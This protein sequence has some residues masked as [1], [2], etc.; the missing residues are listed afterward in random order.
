MWF[1]TLAVIHPP[2]TSLPLVIALS[3]LGLSCG[4]NKNDDSPTAPPRDGGVGDVQ[5]QEVEE[6]G[7]EQ[8]EAETPAVQELPAAVVDLRA[9][10]NRDGLVDLDGTTDSVG[11]D[12]WDAKH[13]AVFLAN[14]DDDLVACPKV[15]ATGLA[16]S[17]IELPKCNDAA[18]E[19]I[20]GDDD[21]LDLARVKTKPWA[22][23]PDDAVG[24]LALN[25]EALPMVRIFRKD[26]DKKGIDGWKVFDTTKDTLTADELRTGVEFGIEGKDII[27]D[28]AVWDGFL[29]ITLHVTAGSTAKGTAGE[30]VDKS[31]TVRLRIAPVLTYHHLLEPE[32]SFAAASGGTAS[33][34]FRKG[35]KQSIGAAGAPDLTEVKISDQWI[36]DYFEPGY[37][38]M[39]AAGG[40][41]HAIRVYYRS[42]NVYNFKSATNPLRQAGKIVFT[43]FRGKDAAGVQEFDLTTP[44]QMESLNSYGNFETIPPYS[45]DGT[46]YPFGRMIRGN[47]A[48]FHPDN[49][50]QK[51]FEAQ[52]MQP[53]VFLD[54]SW[55]LVGHVDETLSFLKASSPRG[56]IVLA[57]DPRLA[58][59][60]LED[61][62]AKGNG[63]TVMFAGRKWVS[64]GAETDAQV[65]IAD[66]LAN[67]EVMTASA[68]AAV[69]VDAQIAILKKE[70]GITDA[71]IVRVPYLHERT[72]GYS[73]AYMVGT[74][75]GLVVSN[76]HFASPDPHGPLV[77]G[78]DL[79]KAQL[80]TALSPYGITV[81]WVEDW[82]LYHRLD[83]E[84]HC[85]TNTVR[86]I[87]ESKWWESGR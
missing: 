46:A 25:A 12:T 47:I 77:G 48:S 40:K 68:E 8:P 74:V 61:Q 39:P 27:R 53:P 57:N 45:K 59:K 30:K 51:L 19:V 2:R 71:E 16:L 70:T 6:V 49:K 54:T 33:L 21:L 87:P 80:E 22:K 76:D 82:D 24:T 36:Q 75:N 5:Q 69:E 50:M 58:K 72:H 60:M 43:L 86:T 34:E 65:S 44:P 62:V 9:D 84:V 10:S 66:V 17:D 15:D 42:A 52:A 78:K 29:N 32:A 13:G 23:A 18:D 20:N 64:T 37:M 79:F 1:T 28:K 85:G 55:L 81:D 3:A 26:S 7:Q 11:K 83:G 56:W 67:T 4:G 38:S 63:S 31:D 35:L 41:Q 14:I 73:I